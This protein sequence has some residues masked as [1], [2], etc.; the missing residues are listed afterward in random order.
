MKEPLVSVIVPVYNIPK[1]LLL[2]SINS[3]INQSYNNIE[4]IIV[5]DGSNDETANFVDEIALSD[6]RIRVI[7]KS[8]QGVSAARNDGTKVAEGDYL[9]YFDADDVLANFVIEEAVGLI[10]KYDADVVYGGI[11]KVKSQAEFSNFSCMKDNSY[12]H[13]LYSKDDIRKVI[14]G[15]INRDLQ[16]IHKVG[17]ISRGPVSRLIKTKIAKRVFFPEN[18]KIGEDIVWNSRLLFICQKCI[19]AKSIW[20]GYVDY[21]ASS[22]SKFYGNRAI[23]IENWF[24]IIKNEN[25]F[26]FNNY[27]EVEGRLLANEYYSIVNFDILPSSLYNSLRQKNKAVHCLLHNKT[28][29]ILKNKKYRQGLSFL[30]KIMILLGYLGFGATSVFLYKKI[31]S[32]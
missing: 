15:G 32:L 3:V 29:I 30:Q 22:I 14:F 27:P 23:I 19:V 9:M 25:K 21:P 11:C 2:Y 10:E 1:E 24:N 26:F 7:H 13:H 5:D 17:Y 8:N 6:S 4:I 16:Q 12:N 18:F 31:K 28:W 20:Y